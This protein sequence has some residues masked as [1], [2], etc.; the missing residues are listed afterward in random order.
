[1]DELSSSDA[2]FRRCQ[3]H[4]VLHYHQIPVSHAESDFGMVYVDMDS[5]LAVAKCDLQVAVAC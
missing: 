4:Q 3:I 5:H 2:S 1:M